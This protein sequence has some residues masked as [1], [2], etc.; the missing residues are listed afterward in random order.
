MRFSRSL[1]NIFLFF[2]AGLVSLVFVEISLRALSI[3]HPAFYIVD[4]QRGYGLRPNARG[5]YSREG[6]SIVAINSAGFRG[7]LP[8]R[9]PAD[10]VFRIAVLGDSFTEALQVN[11]NETW[12]KVL[13]KQLNSLNDCSLLEGRKAEILNFGV[14]GY[15]TGQSLL[16]WR[17]LA[18]KFRPDLVI[19]AVYPGNDFS[20]NEPIA[21]DDRPYFKFSVDGNLEQDNSF[22]LSSS[23]RFRTSIFG[24]LLDNLINHSRTLQLLNESKNRFAALRRESFTFRSSST[25]SPPSPPLPAS[26]E[27]WNLTEALINKLYQEVNVTGARFLVVSTTSPDQVWPIASER[28][29]SVF[30]Q[31][32]R[33]ANLLTSSQISYLS[34]GPLLQHAV[35]E[36]SAIFY[37]HGF[38]D[39]SG[40]GHWNSDGHNVAARQIAPWLCQQ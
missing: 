16:T 18:S 20:D 31:E 8:S 17:Y 21:R 2:G 23:Y 34:L 1:S 37:L 6:H 39:N 12:V 33:L 40:H 9:S 24:L 25:S 11:E 4:A 29:S 10:G 5:I 22:K 28:S 19:L 27:A 35:D 13:Q 15:G 38:S 36:A 3:H 14:G 7:S 30:L 26:S 32:K